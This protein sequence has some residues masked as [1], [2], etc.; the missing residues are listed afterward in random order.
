M[1]S[2]DDT[3]DDKASLGQESEAQEVE[4]H[5]AQARSSNNGD[6]NKKPTWVNVYL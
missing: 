1:D 3:P 6:E 4:G 5:V 2:N